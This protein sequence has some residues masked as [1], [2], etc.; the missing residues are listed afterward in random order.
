MKCINAMNIQI[1]KILRKEHYQIMSIRV[2]GTII[3][4][5][6]QCNNFVMS[7]FGSKGKRNLCL[8]VLKFDFIILVFSCRIA[9]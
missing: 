6:Q 9:Y 3:A 8:E 7:Y 2:N 4:P 1:N 5:M